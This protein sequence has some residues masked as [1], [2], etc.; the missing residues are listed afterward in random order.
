MPKCNLSANTGNMKNRSLQ[1]MRRCIHHKL[2]IAPIVRHSPGKKKTDE[3]VIKHAKKPKPS[4]PL[5]YTNPIFKPKKYDC[6]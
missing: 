3:F 6:L 1:T 4:I 2:A 5:F